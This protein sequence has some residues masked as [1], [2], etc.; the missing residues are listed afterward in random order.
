MASWFLSEFGPTW[1]AGVYCVMRVNIETHV[2][3]V[4][5]IGS[6]KNIARR[7]LKLSHPYRR[8]LDKHTWPEMI[9]LK[10]KECDNYL[11]L[12]IQLIRRLQP[13]YNTQHKA[14]LI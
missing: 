5:Y 14:A 9:V 8:L 10:M 2:S 3:K 1:A 12:E 11:D 6:S 4:L 7:V 13:K